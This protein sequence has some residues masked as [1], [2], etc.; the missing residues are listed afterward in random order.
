MQ[1]YDKNTVSQIKKQVNLFSKVLIL[2]SRVRMEKN[3]CEEC[4]SQRFNI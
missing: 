3:V 4:S 1:S 2:R